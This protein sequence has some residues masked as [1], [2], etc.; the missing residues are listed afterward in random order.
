MAALLADNLA[1]GVG[2]SLSIL[3]THTST[4]AVI[5]LPNVMSGS[6]IPKRS[7]AASI[8]L[9]WKPKCLPARHSSA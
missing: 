8:D 3:S 4:G 9:R 6:T 7:Q 1:F 2:V 5:G